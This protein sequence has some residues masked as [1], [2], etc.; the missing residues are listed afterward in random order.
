MNDVLDL[1]GRVAVCSYS[2]CK[3]TSVPSS[4]GLAF[5]EF[6]G[7]GSERAVRKC[8]QCNYFDVTHWELN[9]TTGRVGHNFGDHDFVPKGAADLDYYYCGCKGWD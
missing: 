5:F 1:E 7:E 8:K 2:D 9:T 3:K 6:M 4:R